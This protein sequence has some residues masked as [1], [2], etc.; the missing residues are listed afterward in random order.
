MNNRTE[1][2]KWKLQTGVVILVA[3]I[4]TC[5]QI[6]SLQLEM[7]SKIL[8]II[9]TMISFAFLYILIFLYIEICLLNDDINDIKKFY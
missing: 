2:T 1:A 7:V 6:N 8:F 4:T 9:F 3:T 5:F